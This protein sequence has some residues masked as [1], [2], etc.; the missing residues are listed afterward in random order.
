MCQTAGSVVSA[1]RQGKRFSQACKPF[2]ATRLR[3]FIC[4]RSP[5]S[6]HIQVLSFQRS[7]GHAPTR[8]PRAVAPASPARTRRDLRSR[9]PVAETGP[10]HPGSR[11]CRTDVLPCSP[12]MVRRV[13]GFPACFFTLLALDTSVHFRVLSPCII[14]KLL[15]VRLY[16]FLPSDFSH[17]TRLVSVRCA[18]ASAVAP[19][20]C[21]DASVEE[22]ARV[23]AGY[24]ISRHSV[25][26]SSH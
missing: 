19:E 26:C 2:V 4:A 14:D 16:T 11:P 18:A 6:A 21:P 5:E 25:G 7:E 1:Y 8:N 13:P 23:G 20:L 22:M 24:G 17:R 12:M 9:G 3:R 15:V 10:V